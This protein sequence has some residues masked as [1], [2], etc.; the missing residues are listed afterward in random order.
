MKL[1]SIK[2]STNKD[3]KLMATFD[4]GRTIHFGSKGMMDYTKYYPKDPTLAKQKKES[5]LARHRVNEDWNDVTSAGSLSR[6]IL[7]NKPTIEASVKDFK[8]RF[9]L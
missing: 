4:N 5:Y 9:N 1:L 7:W 6:W 3:K 8:N 2:P